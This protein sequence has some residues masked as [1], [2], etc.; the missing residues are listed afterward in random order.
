MNVNKKKES[1]EKE[2]LLAYVADLSGTTADE[3]KNKLSDVKE[4][5]SEFIKKYPLTSVAIA[6]GVGFM[7]G[8]L[9]KKGK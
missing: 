2:D 3:M 6:A 9:L 5:A 8:R 4:E 7:L 1:T